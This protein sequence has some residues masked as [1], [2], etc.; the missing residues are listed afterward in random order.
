MTLPRGVLIAI[1]K[2]VEAEGGD[3]A[4]VEDLVATWERVA[5]R[6]SERADV[7]RRE[8]AEAD[9]RERVE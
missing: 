8:V 9:C 5:R 6:N 2:A 3:M 4:D 7:I 1:A